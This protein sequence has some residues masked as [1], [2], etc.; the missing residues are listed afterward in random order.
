MSR[1]EIYTGKKRREV[2]GKEQDAAAVSGVAGASMYTFILLYAIAKTVS[3]SRPVAS[4]TI[5][6]WKHWNLEFSQ[7]LRTTVQS[8]TQQTY[9]N[10]LSSSA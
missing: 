5:E 3:R 1:V 2:A 9:S 6:H 10:M 8:I 4:S 7:P